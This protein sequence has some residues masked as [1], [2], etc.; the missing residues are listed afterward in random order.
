MGSAG[1][2]G[3][4]CFLKNALRAWGKYPQ[5]ETGRIRGNSPCGPEAVDSQRVVK[6][7]IVSVTAS[8]G[9]LLSPLVEAGSL[10][11]GHLT[12][13]KGQISKFTM[14]LKKRFVEIGLFSHL[15]P[16]R[17]DNILVLL[18][19]NDGVDVRIDRLGKFAEGVIKPTY[20]NWLPWYMKAD[21][22]GEKKLSALTKIS[23]RVCWKMP[24]G[25]LDFPERLYG[26]QLGW[27]QVACQIIGV[28]GIIY[29]ILLH[30]QQGEH[31]RDK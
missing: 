22:S 21:E 31:S 3:L 11:V 25:R 29:E 23:G 4:S 19:Q 14:I 18:A 5:T 26:G 20:R 6:R 1:Q 13:T 24:H 27:L 9:Q 7:G 2:N 17:V 30:S 10:R 12:A 28:I 15:Y 8:N 16:K